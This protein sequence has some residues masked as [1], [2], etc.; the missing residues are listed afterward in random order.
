MADPNPI[1]IVNAGDGE[2]RVDLWSYLDAEAIERAE[3]DAN[4]WIKSLRHVAV[5]GV[6]LRDRFL[7]R[8]DSL[9]WFAELYLHKRR[10]V[11]AILRTL[12][13]LEALAA[14][15]RPLT[16]GL[17]AGD[18]RRRPWSGSSRRAGRSG[19]GDRRHRVAPTGSGGP[20]PHGEARGTGRARRSSASGPAGARTF[21]RSR[22]PSRRSCTRRS[23]GRR[24]TTSRTSARSCV[25]CRGGS[26]VAAWRWSASV[27]AHDLPPRRL[28]Q[29][30]PGVVRRAA[31]TV[32]FSPSSRYAS[33]TRCGPRAGVWRDR[34][35]HRRALHGSEALRAACVF[36][37]ATRGRCSATSS[38]ASPICSSR[39]RRA[40]WT[41]SARR[42]T[43]WSRA[44][45]SPTPKP[46]A[47][48]GPSSSRR[49]G[50]ASRSSAC[51]TASSTATG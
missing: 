10:V 18:P 26:A 19:G 36:G 41:R 33:R 44:S 42:S 11:V 21:R 20:S 45:P 40:R 43:R 46:A 28:A 8:G 12:L 17:A 31:A 16:L 51:S 13:A 4:A 14:R 25:R 23:G 1:L 49:A 2:R 48:G 27:R 30:W 15:E 34:K 22:S 24:P 37:A 5:D 29:R 39:G 50:A 6:P 47:G 9:W 35:A 38:P 3:R 32:P 7:F